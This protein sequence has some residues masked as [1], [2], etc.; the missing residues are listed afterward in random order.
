MFVEGF[1]SPDEVSS[2][3]KDDSH[4]VVDELDHLV[5]LADSLSRAEN[6]MN[7]FTASMTQTYHLGCQS[8]SS[9]V[10]NLKT[11]PAVMFP[12][13]RRSYEYKAP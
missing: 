13:A 12:N 9:N 10:K 4:P 2:I 3:L 11:E 7:G 6:V 5:V 1:E 8:V